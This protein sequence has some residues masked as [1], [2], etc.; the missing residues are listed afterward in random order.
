MIPKKGKISGILR[1]FYESH[2]V[3]S[4]FR[5]F[6]LIFFKKEEYFHMFYFR[7]TILFDR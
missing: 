6:V 5:V 4:C 2:I 7:K 3:R 1:E